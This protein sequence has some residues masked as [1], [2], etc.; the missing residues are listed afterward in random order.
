MIGFVPLSITI[1]NGGQVKRPH[2]ANVI[3]LGRKTLGTIDGPLFG[4]FIEIAGRG[5]NNGVYEPGS[6]NSREDGV[7]LD[8]MEAL[9]E[10]RPTHIRYPGG[11]ATAYFDWQDL[12]GPVKERPRTR[13][14]RM[15]GVP[16]STAFGI[17]EAWNYCRE[18]GAELYLTVNAHTQSPEDAANLVEYLNGT[19]PSKWAD[20]RRIHGR[21]QPYGVK[22]FSLGNEIY[23]DW[24]A[25]QKSIE[26][27]VKW[28]REAIRQMKLVDPTIQ[29]VVCGLGRPCPEWDRTLLFGT[30]GMA[31]MISAHNYFG[32][33]VFRDNMSA[34]LVFEQMVRALDVAI[35]E[36]CDTAL[37]A[38]SRTYRNFGA[39]PEVKVRP[40]IAL[41][42]W[43]VWYRAIHDPKKDLEEVYNYMD[44]LTVGSLFHVMLRNTRIVGLSNISEAVNMA[45]SI[46][47]DRER[48]VRQT[49]WHSQRLMRDGHDSGRVVETV[50]DCPTF[51]AKHERFFCG[52]VSPEK[53]RDEKL[54]SLLH[55][56]EVPGL[57]VLTSVDEKKRRMTVSVVQKLE[58]EPITAKFQ[59]LGVSP[60][61]RTVKASTLTGGKNLLT[62]NT[63][64]K[65]DRV[66]TA[67][68]KIAL[69]DRMVFPPAS[70]TV[71]EFEV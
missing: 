27:Y 28:C 53:A 20:L 11:C 31:D 55:F 24:Q 48:M 47:T 1:P 23:G 8:V 4:Q 69:S 58:K 36:A 68:R 34:S 18:L 46:L 67:S 50:V 40:R 10:L 7:R 9:R 6:P 3:I 51:A 16:Q 22:L 59:F 49:I 30:V 70:L 52:I 26:D 54:P 32:R 56:P 44:A 21:E 15:T 12:V 60:K 64:S 65:P 66:G 29:I 5:V 71:L 42:E 17:P 45:A 63:L 37:G 62:E 13:V 33:P 39:A 57:D 25:G 35:D 38:H 43:N 19:T 41:D 2:E 14:F 61:G